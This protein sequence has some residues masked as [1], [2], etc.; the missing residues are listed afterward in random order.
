MNNATQSQSIVQ[1]PFV[2]P[3]QPSTTFVPSSTKL[4]PS[5]TTLAPSPTTLV[6]SPTTL[7]PSPTTL[8][9][10]TMLVPSPTTLAPSTMLVP[11]PSTINTPSSI[12]QN[13][14]PLSTPTFTPNASFT[15]PYNIPDI[16]I[17]DDSNYS[18]L[19]MTKNSD[20]RTYNIPNVKVCC[21]GNIV[22]IIDKDNIGTDLKYTL[23]NG[24]IIDP[25]I[26]LQST[27]K[28][29]YYYAI[30]MIIDNLNKLTNKL[31]TTVNRIP[32]PRPY[33][34]KPIR[35]EIAYLW[36]AGLASH[37]YSGAAIGPAFLMNFFNSCMLK[38]Q[39]NNNLLK[40]EQ[41]FTYEL[42]RNYIFPDTVYPLIDYNVY[43]YLDRNNPNK[44]F[45]YEYNY[46]ACVTQGFV[47]IL[48]GILTLDI[49][50]PVSYNYSGFD[51]PRMF[52]MMED[53]L[54]I[55]ING[56]YTWDD[57]FMY[58][59]LIWNTSQSLDNLYSGLFIRLWKTYNTSGN[60]LVR[61]FNA[62]TLT[63]PMRHPEVF[64]NSQQ[65]IQTYTDGNLNVNRSELRL[66]SQ[67]AA[68]N[69]YIAS[70][71]GAKQDL[72]T[73]FTVTLRRSIRQEARNY[74]LNLIS[75]NP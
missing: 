7:V 60:F 21:G 16:E 48:G 29:I 59:R 23:S 10:S 57:V 22:I 36:A 3:V 44:K 1:T 6:P 40:F 42:C 35:I 37:G 19:I 51:L 33:R 74:A 15:L 11:S 61:F 71:Y 50:P 45:I 38:L 4:V 31:A 56:T 75:N 34:N 68:E 13:W 54:D 2:K 52:K 55:Y 41:I 5:P 62:I 24:S 12:N 9:P 64:Q 14:S 73:Y 49:N 70:S 27:N 20:G 67:T 53:H 65:N 32:V 58:D 72:Y 28:N 8:A 46:T 43:N 30:A 26:D 66:N 69:F 17:F 25:I 39:N 63:I 47:N 18:S